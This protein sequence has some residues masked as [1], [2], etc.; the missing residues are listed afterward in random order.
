[1]RF[2]FTGGFKD[3]GLREGGAER[4]GGVWLAKVDKSHLMHLGG[5]W[6]ASPLK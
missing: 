2:M 1:M 3:G 6:L 5:P 4:L